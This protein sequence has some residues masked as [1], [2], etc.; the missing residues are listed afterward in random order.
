MTYTQFS[1]L[2]LGMHIKTGDCTHAFEGWGL[3]VCLHRL[4]NFVLGDLRNIYCCHC[5]HL[6][7]SS[8]LGSSW[9]LGVMPV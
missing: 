6:K 5:T 9:A 7:I 4:D 8:T 2:Q 1:L 3:T